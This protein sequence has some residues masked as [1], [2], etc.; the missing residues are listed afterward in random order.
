MGRYVP[1]D[2]A[3]ACFDAPHSPLDS[4]M[5]T[6]IEQDEEGMG[7]E[8]VAMLLAQVDGCEVPLHVAT[9]HKLVRGRST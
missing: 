8:A 7:C 2:Y 4:A 6:Y 5:L 9:R 3:I 1:S